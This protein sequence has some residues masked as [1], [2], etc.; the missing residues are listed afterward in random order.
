MCWTGALSTA[1]GYR[2]AVAGHPDVRVV[3]G[4]YAA[5]AALHQP[6]ERQINGAPD[7]GRA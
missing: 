4:G 7:A 3:F 2:L 6:A 5:W 1:A